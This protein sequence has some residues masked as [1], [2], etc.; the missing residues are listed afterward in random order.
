MYLHVTRAFEFFKDDFVHPAT[1]VN[2]GRGNN[3]QAATI[4]NISRGT[5]KLLRLMKRIGVD[6]TG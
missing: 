6:P 4:L 2:Q 3:G 5:E 1:S